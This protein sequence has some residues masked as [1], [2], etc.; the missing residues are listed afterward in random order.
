MSVRNEKTG[1]KVVKMIISVL[2]IIVLLLLVGNVNEAVPFEFTEEMDEYEGNHVDTSGNWTFFSIPALPP[3]TKASSIFGS[4]NN[5]AGIISV[6]STKEGKWEVYT[7]D[8]IDNDNMDSVVSGKGYIAHS[9][10]K[11]IIPL[12]YEPAEQDAPSMPASVSLKQGWNLIEVYGSPSG[13][14]R[15]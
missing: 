6:W 9:D 3:D 12:D 14:S 11:T 7:P 5:S 15:D 13:N 8:G 4:G 1:Y 10:S 2:I